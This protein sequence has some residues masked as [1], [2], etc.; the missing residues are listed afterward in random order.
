MIAW[1]NPQPPVLNDSSAWA[2]KMRELLAQRTSWNLSCFRA[3][4]RV[5]ANSQNRLFNFLKISSLHNMVVLS[6]A[7]L[8]S[9]ATIKIKT[10]C[11]VS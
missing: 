3:L 9:K 4:L 5:T 11:P 2:S 6:G 1:G 7:L 8:S 10:A